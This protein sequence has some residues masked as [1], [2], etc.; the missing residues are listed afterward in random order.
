MNAAV[1]AAVTIGINPVV[2]EMTIKIMIAREREGPF[3]E[4][5]DLSD[6][7]V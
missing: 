3:R 4:Q 5:E 2:A 1:T 6:L 7:F